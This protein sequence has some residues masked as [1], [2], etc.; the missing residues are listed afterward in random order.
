MHQLAAVLIPFGP[1]Q[2]SIR[3]LV[4]RDAAASAQLGTLLYRYEQLED[5]SWGV[6]IER[7]F[8]FDWWT[9]GGRWDGWGREVRSLMTRQRLRPA[10]RSLPRF[11]ERNSVWSEDLTRVRL[12]SALTP[13]SLVTPHGEWKESSALFGFGK[14]TLRERKAKAAWLRKMRQV[15]EMYPYC[16]AI[17]VDY[18][19]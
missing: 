1:A 11:L 4:A 6:D 17:G 9:R 13:V 10:P 15:I 8:R 5:Q 12:I 19:C 3:P 7:G 16:L 14:P 2:T 18:H